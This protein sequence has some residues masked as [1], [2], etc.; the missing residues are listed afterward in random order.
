[1]G[2][3]RNTPTAAFYLMAAAMACSLS[4]C[5][6]VSQHISGMFDAMSIHANQHR[7][8]SNIRQDTRAKLA[9]QR[10][11]VMRTE[12]QREI[13]QARIDAQRQQLEAEFC[14]ANQEQKQRQVQEQL[15]QR[16]QSK[17]AFN[18]EQGLE[19][20]ELEVDMEALKA[21]LE[22]REQEQNQP[23]VPNQPQQGKQP[24]A[25]CDQP[26]GCRP[27][28]IRRLCPHCC[29]KPCEAEKKC[30]GP[31]S[32][33]QLQQQPQKQPLK[34][35]EIPMKLPV[36]LTF[37]FQQPQLEQAQIRRLP[38]PS[39]PQQGG[40]CSK[41]GMP[42][43][44][45]Q[46]PDSCVD[47]VHIAPGSAP[48]GGSQE[49]PLSPPKPEPDA[50]ASFSPGQVFTTLFPTSTPIVKKRAAGSSKLNSGDQ[51]RAAGH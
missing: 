21:L 49:K 30:G 10:E 48:V 16:L 25:C 1:M 9:Q 44:H 50:E 38:P 39:Q 13:E 45:C 4:G 12:A 42:Y 20:G 29:N 36:K 3:R 6:A 32:F 18:V 51:S 7:E 23:Q 24:C 35:A 17:V 2:T 37:G 27:G 31:E 15:R 41:C 11:V 47:P 8:L 19:V 40:P 28:L 14:I 43:G 46:C 34:P 26:C 5:A 22:K 33:A